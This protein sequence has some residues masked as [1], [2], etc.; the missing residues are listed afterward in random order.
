[1]KIIIHDYA[2]HPFQYDLSI[3]LA[4]RG[5]EVIHIYFYNDI[6]PKRE[7]SKRIKNLKIIP[8][9]MSY[10][11]DNFIKRFF[12]DI[13]YSSKLLEQLKLNKS[14][15]IISGN[16]PSFIQYNLAKFSNQ[17][18]IKFIN[19]IQDIYSLAVIKI[20]K[21]KKSFFWRDRWIYI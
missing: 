8:I 10:T 19:W 4:K 16:S 3:E 12:L 7:F 21:K 18:N 1:M 14:D 2:G 9:K 13:S 20:L 15:V 11:K 17:N 6:G 5:H